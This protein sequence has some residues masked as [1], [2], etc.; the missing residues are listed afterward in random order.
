MSNDRKFIRI[1]DLDRDTRLFFT[2]DLEANETVYITQGG[3]IVAAVVMIN[4]PE[5]AR[6]A[7]DEMFRRNPPRD[8]EEAADTVTTEEILKMLESPEN[9]DY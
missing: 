6:I 3:K 9:S 8:P 4:Y 5:A 2:Q 7:V 1:E